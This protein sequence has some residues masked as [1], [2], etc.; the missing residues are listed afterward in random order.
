[1]KSPAV[2]SPHSERDGEE[3][4]EEG[5]REVQQGGHEYIIENYTRES[6]VRELEKKISKVMRKIALEIASD[7]FTGTMS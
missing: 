1:M 2:T 3:R 7:E 4:A 5:T 6:G